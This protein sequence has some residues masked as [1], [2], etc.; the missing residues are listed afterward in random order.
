MGLDLDLS[1]QL[2]FNV[3]FLKLILEEDLKSHNILTLQQRRKQISIEPR[4]KKKKKKKKRR[5]CAQKNRVANKRL[6]TF[7]S[8]ARYTF[9]NLPLPRG[10]PM[11]KSFKDQYR[12]RFLASSTPSLEGAP[13]SVI[14]GR[15]T[16]KSI[17]SLWSLRVS[18]SSVNRQHY[19]GKEYRWYY[20]CRPEET[21]DIPWF[22][23]LSLS[24][25]DR[26]R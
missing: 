25:L 26:L 13:F 6:T 21:Q 20:F 18:L 15:E 16:L 5:T 22:T 24:Y 11:S 14:W 9:P 3:T 23:S 10:F 12:D 2:M 8:L 19:N 4:Q 17:N 1:T 7:F